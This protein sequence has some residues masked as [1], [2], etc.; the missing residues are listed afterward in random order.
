METLF[1]HLLNMSINA[2]WI[3]LAVLLLRVVLRK[4][5]RWLICTL[6][7]LVG[8]RLVL[9]FSIESIFSLI[10]SAET[11]P[12]TIVYEKA[13]AIDS[14]IAPVDQIINPIVAGSFTPDPATSAN[15]LQIWGT[16]ASFVWIIGAILM[17]G[18]MIFGYLRLRF[19]L[20]TATK[21]GERVYAAGAVDSPFILG[22]FRPRI[23]IPYGFD[24]EAYRHVYEHEMAHL[25]RKDHFIKPLAFL[26]LA[27]YWF[28]PLMW[29]AYIM[30]C[31]DIEY[32]C[33]EKVMR[34]WDR[35]A[36]RAYSKTM[37]ACS[38]EP[39]ALRACPLAF[40]EVSVKSRV[41]KVMN[42]K[43][44]SFGLI[45]LAILSIIVTS[46]CF[47]T[48]PKT[49]DA[50]ADVYPPMYYAAEKITERDGTY[51]SDPAY[52]PYFYIDERMNLYEKRQHYITGSIIEEWKYCGALEKPEQTL[53]N[54]EVWE[55]SCEDE[56][57]NPSVRTF[58]FYE[59]GKVQYTYVRE[60]GQYCVCKMRA[61][62]DMTK[63]L[64]VL[65]IDSLREGIEISH[66]GTEIAYKNM[67]LALWIQN[68]TGYCVSHQGHEYYVDENGENLVR[69]VDDVRLEK[70]TS[71]GWIAVEYISPMGWGMASGGGLT[72]SF[73]FDFASTSKRNV[74]E[75]GVYRLTFS[76]DLLSELVDPSSENYDGK[77]VERNVPCAEIV[78]EIVAPGATT[79]DCY[80]LDVEDRLFAPCFYLYG[81]DRASVSFG[82]YSS[83]LFIGTYELRDDV[84]TITE[85]DGY[86][87][88]YVFHKQGDAYIYD[89]EN[90]SAFLYNSDLPDGAVFQRVSGDYEESS[91]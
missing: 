37:L 54:V 22:I 70:K 88:R 17:V 72:A 20:R 79:A 71:D 86:N 83:H 19:R 34:D 30:L 52:I 55:V 65:S 75:N 3:V 41:K 60:D 48:N 29:V 28:N 32:A 73:N 36:R 23:Y 45:I 44:P 42:Y 9:P 40:G 51:Y 59:N 8:L 85:T 66:F 1:F 10:P 89:K 25:A 53:P 76:V 87:L 80:A 11:V 84:L 69:L 33:D 82:I 64:N 63:Q 49:P 5:P 15:P 74:L 50:K 2:G 24:E 18:Y 14:G 47:L 31:R 91:S 56:Y 6:W 77:C 57:G 16:I 35:G 78:F 12:P 62:P 7:G 46:I 43:K 21:I 67:K 81:D 4:A 68:N 90:S 39:H 58:T 13:P 27:V 61:V 38:M 26:I